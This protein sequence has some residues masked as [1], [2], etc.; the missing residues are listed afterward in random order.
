MLGLQIPTILG[1]TF[2]LCWFHD[3]KAMEI[4][5]LR[6]TSKGSTDEGIEAMVDCVVVSQIEY[7]VG[8]GR[9]SVRAVRVCM[10]GVPQGSVLGPVLLSLHIGVIPVDFSKSF[11]STAAPTSV[12]YSTFFV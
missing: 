9:T 6:G 12:L 2:Q 5:A 1:N 8:T 4:A 3:R 11:V 7:R 10:T